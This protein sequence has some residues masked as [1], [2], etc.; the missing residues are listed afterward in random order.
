M[1][2]RLHARAALGAKTPSA[3]SHHRIVRFLPNY[4]GA[5]ASEFCGVGEVFQRLSRA[6]ANLC[7]LASRCSSVSVFGTPFARR[8]RACAALFISRTVGRVVASLTQQFGTDGFFRF[9][10][11]PQSDQAE[12]DGAGERGLLFSLFCGVRCHAVSINRF[13]VRNKGNRKSFL[14]RRNGTGGGG[15]FETLRSEPRQ[16]SNVGTE[17]R[18]EP[19]TD[20]ASDK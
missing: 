11:L 13:S 7:L 15:G 8:P 16:K 6:A 19:R 4:S 2:Q 14:R 10:F 18:R 17:Q 1:T 5:F 9:Q 3:D 12:P 20:K